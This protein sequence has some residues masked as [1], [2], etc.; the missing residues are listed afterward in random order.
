MKTLADR[1]RTERKSAGLT[2]TELAKKSGL[3]H[4]SHIANLENEYRKGSTHLP[5][6]ADALGLHAIWLKNGTGPKY[7]K[8]EQSIR[9]GLY[10]TD[11]RI[12]AIAQT[13]L[14][15]ME[16][17]NDYLVEK[18]QKELDLGNEFIAQATARAKAKDR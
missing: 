8:A 2:Q 6:I 15:A 12:V 7:L 9:D 16:E 4:Q 5:N 13:L 14:R 10:V 18:T 1:L 17:G 3:K 11:P